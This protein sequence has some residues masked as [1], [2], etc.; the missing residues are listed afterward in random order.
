[1]ET[2][3]KN[4]HARVCVSTPSREIVTRHIKREIYAPPIICDRSFCPTHPRLASYPLVF[5]EWNS[6]SAHP[7]SLGPWG[8]QTFSLDQQFS[9]F[10]PG[11]LRRTTNSIRRWIDQC[12]DLCILRLRLFCETPSG[13]S[14]RVS[15][16]TPPHGEGN[17]TLASFFRYEFNQLIS[18]FIQ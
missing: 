7:L 10:F 6:S 18:R 14:P 15:I 5:Y 8:L 11:R 4:F 13:R 1:M 12:S 3:G 2:R 17:R 16:L 9:A